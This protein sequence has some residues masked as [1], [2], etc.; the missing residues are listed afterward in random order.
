MEAFMDEHPR[1]RHGTVVYRAEA[2]GI[3]RAERYEAL[4]SYIERFGVTREASTTRPER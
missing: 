3:D 2:V 1:G 4:D